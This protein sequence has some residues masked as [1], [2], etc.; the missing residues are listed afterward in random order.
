MKQKKVIPIIAV[1]CI[2]L[3]VT[4]VLAA[5]GD[6]IRVSLD[7]SGVQ[8]N[9]S[10]Y[11]QSISAD[12]RYVAFS[13]LA[14]NLVSGDTNGSSDIFMHD[15]TSGVTTR[16]S[17]DSSGAQGNNAS[18]TPSISDDGR[19][20]AY[21][22]GASNLVSGDTNGKL[23]IFVNEINLTAPTVEF[24][25]LSQPPSNG[26]TLAVGPS[27]LVVSFAQNV[28]A[29]GSQHAANSLQNYMLLR[30]GGNNTF[31]TGSTSAAI[32]D[33]AHTPSVDDVLISLN[34]ISYDNVNHVATLTINPA[35]A[36]L[37]GGSYRLYVCGESSIWNLRSI[38]LNSGANTTIGFT[39][40]AGGGTGGTGST[41][42]STVSSIPATGFTP[43]K[44]TRLPR[45]SDAYTDQ[46]SLSLEIPSLGVNMPVTGVPR[47]GSSW[48]VTWLGEEAGW[49]EG[50][51]FPSWNGNSVLTGHVWNADNTPGAF[52]HLDNLKWGDR[53]IIHYAGQQYTYEVRGMEQVKPGDVHAM[54]RH[55]ET[56]WLTLVTCKGFDEKTDN[57]RERLLVRAALIEVK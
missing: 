44:V 46:G 31:D 48:D 32:C 56:P 33:A 15:T 42:S 25:A 51:A 6:T 20:V 10:S 16:A 5:P 35:F 28:L 36:P 45:Q 41:G 34:S 21:S 12:G 4:P 38:P 50:T 17:V 14:S 49:L 11:R 3:L 43:G 53:I 18:Y 1:L 40:S 29:D 27:Q 52:R 22:S 24:N 54:L 8:E 30:P 39:V 7:S 19:Y 26:A 57:Y 37:A 2:L 55:E 13:S 47:Q 23:D 9:G